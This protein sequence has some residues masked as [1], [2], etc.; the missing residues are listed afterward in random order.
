MPVVSKSNGLPA[1]IAIFPSEIDQQLSLVATLRQ[2]I[3]DTLRSQSGFVSA[4]LFQSRSGL[5]VTSYIQWQNAE[6]YVPLGGLNGFAT[7]D[8]HLFEIFAE[9]PQDSI[10]HPAVPMNGLINFGVFKLKKPEH[11]PRFVALFEEALVMVAGQPGLISTHAH[12]SLDGLRCIN[13]GFWNSQE[14]FTAMDTNR[15]FSPLFGE[16]LDLTN[17]EYEKKLH[18]IVYILDT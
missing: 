18:E 8:A 3:E 13:F 9:E 4:T 14:A 12:R 15:P 2:Y 1:E 16:M 7:P 5:R 6:V 17:N 10:L 11:Q